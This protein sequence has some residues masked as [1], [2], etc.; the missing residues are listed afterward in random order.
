MPDEV[1]GLE[2]V[3]VR[4][5]T[6]DKLV[7]RARPED[8]PDDGGCLQCRLLRLSEQVDA[9]GEHGLDRVWDLEAGRQLAHVPASVGAFE[10]AGVDEAL[11]N[12]FDEERV[13]FGLP[14]DQR[15]QLLGQVR[16]CQH[17]LGHAHARLARQRGEGEAGV[18]SPLPEGMAVPRAIGQDVKDTAGRDAVGEGQEIFFCRLV[19]PVKVLVDHDLRLRLRGAGRQA[20]EGIEDLPATLLRIHAQ[21]GRIAGADREEVEHER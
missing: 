1:A 12:L 3:E 2:Q 10:D 16:G 17:R 14:D 4:R 9:R 7:D 5:Q 8:A 13:S 15:C 19:D 11:Q 20:P 6:F 18:V 21:H